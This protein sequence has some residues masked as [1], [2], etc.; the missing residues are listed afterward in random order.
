ML[1]RVAIGAAHRRKPWIVV[2]HFYVTV[3]VDV[4]ATSPVRVAF[5]CPWSAFKRNIH[6]RQNLLHRFRR[7]PCLP[8][9]FLNRQSR[10]IQTRDLFPVTPHHRRRAPVTAAAPLP[11]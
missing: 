4:S 5:P 2:H 3:I 6:P 10:G 1:W 7:D 8:L 11:P 9:Y